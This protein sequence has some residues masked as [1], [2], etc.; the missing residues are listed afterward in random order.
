MWHVADSFHLLANLRESFNSA[1]FFFS[2]LSDGSTDS[3]VIE[4]EAIYVRYLENG[5]PQTKFAR[6]KPPIK[7][8]AEGLLL[9]IEDVFKSLR[10]QDSTSFEKEEY[11]TEIR[12]KLVNCNFNGA[13]VMSGHASGVQARIKRKQPAVVYTHCIA[14]RLELADFDLIRCDN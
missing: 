1:R 6:I 11:L 5:C 10:A 13:S 14:H 9:V 12:K 8:D 2:V 7:G 3:K 4:Q